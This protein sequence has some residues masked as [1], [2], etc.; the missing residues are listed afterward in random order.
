M[1]SAATLLLPLLA[2]LGNSAGALYIAGQ[3]PLEVSDPF[4][5]T[6][7]LDCQAGL[8]RNNLGLEIERHLPGG[9]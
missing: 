2:A 5:A 9:L 6:R 3:H 1:T 7:L 4:E 8:T